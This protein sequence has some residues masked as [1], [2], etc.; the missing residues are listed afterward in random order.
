M[1]SGLR[2]HQLMHA[3]GGLPSTIYDIFLGLKRT[4]KLA[5]KGPSTQARQEAG[6]AVQV[7]RMQ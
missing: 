3:V 1:S 7:L 4:G 5:T 6:T 2:P